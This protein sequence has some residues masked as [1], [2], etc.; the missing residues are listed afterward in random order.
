MFAARAQEKE[1][2]SKNKGAMVRERRQGDSLP[3]QKTTFIL[4]SSACICGP[5]AR[6]NIGK[7]AAIQG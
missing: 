1:M 6:S 5:I 4:I 7:W 2:S 3:R